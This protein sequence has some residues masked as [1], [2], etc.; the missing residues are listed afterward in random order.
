M[1]VLPGFFLDFVSYII[2]KKTWPRH[3]CQKRLARLTLLGL[4]RQTTFS[5]LTTFVSAQSQS[6]P[7]TLQKSNLL[8]SH[9]SPHF[10]G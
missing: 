9:S 4:T 3:L 6:Y 1:R 2:A 10:L 5:F 8:S 7:F